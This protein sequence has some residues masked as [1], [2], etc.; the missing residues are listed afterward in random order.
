MNIVQSK[1][2]RKKKVLL[3]T[4]PFLTPICPPLGISCIKGFVQPHGY[5]VTTVDGMNE[6]ALREWAYTYFDTL[7][8]YIPEKKRGHFFNVGLDVLNNH[9]MAFTNHTDKQKYEILV[10][11]IVA[12]NFFVQIDK[13]QIDELN[14]IVQNFFI[15]LKTFIL[16]LVGEHKPDVLGLSV[17]RGTLPASLFA[18]KTVKEMYPD[19]LTIMGG[20][21]FSQEL[22]VNSPN[23]HRFMERAPYVDKMIIGEG[24][25]I[26]LKILNGELPAEQ[27]VFMIE[28]IKEGLLELDEMPLPDFS[29]FEIS[30]YPLLPTY[31]S[32]GCTFRCSFCAETVY[33][34]KYRKK[35][36]K[37]VVDEFITLNEKYGRSLFV[38]TDC[39]INPLVNNLVDEIIKRD[40]QLYW[41]VYLKVDKNV[42]NPECTIKW[43]KGGFYRAR[44]G[45]ESGSQRVLDM[46]DKRIT[47]DEIRAAIT[48]LASAG[49]KTTTYWFSGHPGETEE[50]F[51]Q[52][53]DLLEELQDYIYEAECDPFRYFHTGQV[54]ADVWANEI[55][56][57]YL[58]PAEATDMLLTQTWVLK[59]EPGR[60][61][62][63]SRQCRFKEKC[64]E[65]GIPNPY[66][67]K[68]IQAADE[69]WKRLHK[70]AV[71]MIT[72]LAKGVVS[73]DECKNVKRILQV[74]SQLT[75]DTEFNF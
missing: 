4:L 11:D 14:M 75:D 1:Q 58:Y 28:D 13:E 71:P 33:W 62:I 43:R 6:L 47:L 66:S 52:T 32:R 44:L 7:E 55:G 48:S 34:K 69:R 67:L 10:E 9:F 31:T 26:F 73:I 72:D 15:E 29:D 42:C 5:D 49:I 50:D 17:Y 39:V 57:E 54:N 53:L 24:E 41:D 68:E 12:K 21:I 16:R 40:L 61:E 25:L 30:N 19:V 3:L 51:Q 8:S 20:A 35:E 37:K 64:K 45:I 70:N 60:E 36:A 22:F 2:E 18:L 38:L 59:A 63:Y 65:L 46:I 74:E 27:K 56:N 23:Y